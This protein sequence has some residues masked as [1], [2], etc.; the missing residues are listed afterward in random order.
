MVPLSLHLQSVPLNTNSVSRCHVLS[1][2]S[3][4]E[5]TVNP[6]PP[7]L[8]VHCK[9]NLIRNRELWCDLR[10]HKDK[11]RLAANTTSLLAPN[12]RLSES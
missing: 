12:N 9:I 11:D 1:E 10:I 5:I 2:H 4:D 8:A 3:Q 6:E 7:F